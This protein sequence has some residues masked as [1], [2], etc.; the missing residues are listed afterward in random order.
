MSTIQSLGIGSG[1]NIDEI[2]TAIVD[3]E[4]VPKEESLTTKV[5]TAEAKISAYGEIKSRLSTLQSSISSLKQVGNFN[6]KEVTTDGS[7]FTATATSL[8]TPSR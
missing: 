7:A 5:E 6:K 2:V 3:A 1:L 4:R 8:Y